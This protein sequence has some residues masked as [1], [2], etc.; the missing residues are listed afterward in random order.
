MS[1]LIID[2]DNA[3]RFT[4]PVNYGKGL[5][6]RDYSAQP[7]G[8]VQGI[9]AYSGAIK[10]KAECIEL[11]KQRIAEGAT[12]RAV[13][14][15]FKLP[16]YNQGQTNYCW[17]NAVIKIMTYLQAKSGQKIIKGSAASCGAIIKK[18]RN[19]GGWGGEAIDFLTNRGYV[20][21][22]NPD[23]PSEIWW[24]NNAIDRKYDTPENEARRVKFRAIECMELENGNLDQLRTVL[25]DGWLVAAGLSWWG[26]EILITD[27]NPEDLYDFDNS[28]ADTW[29]DRGRGS[30]TPKKAQG[31]Y[32]AIRTMTAA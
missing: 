6:P 13:A 32:V 26:H 14:E 17:I 30:L 3:W 11:A 18:F 4:K 27:Y 31:D 9:R 7:Y 12:N 19:E 15:L 28:W 2:E 16:I 23:N 25:V 5:I 10:T 29:G 22:F 24:P 21:E 8:S 20:P 1:T